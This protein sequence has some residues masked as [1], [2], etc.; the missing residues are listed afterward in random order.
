MQTYHKRVSQ[1]FSSFYFSP[2]YKNAALKENRKLKSNKEEQDTDI[3]VK[4]LK[5]NAEFFAE[6][7]SS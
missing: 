5:D 7:I 3:H 6:Y 4:F 1:R 2:V